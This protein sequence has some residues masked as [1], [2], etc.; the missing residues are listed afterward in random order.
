MKR[1]I[2]AFVVSAALALT[3]AACTAS[4]TQGGIRAAESSLNVQ[5]ASANAARAANRDACE[6]ALATW[7]DVKQAAGTITGFSDVSAIAA[8]FST[9]T[10]DLKKEADSAADGMVRFDINAMTN[11]LTKISAAMN[12]LDTAAMGAA[13]TDFNNAGDDLQTSCAGAE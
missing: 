12:A 6:K 2:P 3:L 7:A 4:H 11:A 10:A 1:L 9:Y 5:V 13:V 8:T